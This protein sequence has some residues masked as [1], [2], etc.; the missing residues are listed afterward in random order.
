MSGVAT[1]TPGIPNKYPNTTTDRIARSGGSF[2]DH[3]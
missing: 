1:T 3:S 2:T